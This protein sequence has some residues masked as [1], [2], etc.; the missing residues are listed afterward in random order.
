MTTRRILHIDA[1]ARTG[2]SGIDPRGSHSRR[3]THRFVER[4]RSARPGDV[5]D[6]RDV[7]RAPPAPVTGAWIAAAFAPPERRDAEA[8]ARLA[9][10]DRL[11][12]ELI[13][14]DIVVIGAPMYNFGVPA[15]LK[16]WID[17][18]V[19]VGLTFGFDRKRADVPY[20]PLLPPGKRLVVLSS[21]GDY[22][23]DP[24]GRLDASNLV[25]RG[26]AV[27]MAY[28]GLSD[29]RSVAVEYDEFGD[30]RFAASIA[31]AERAVDALVDR[32]VG[33]GPAATDAV[34][35]AETGRAP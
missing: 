28:I 7:G 3:L 1:S 24:G 19:R 33:E 35:P 30:A 13:G 29:V 14:A 31:A 8:R 27:P 25:E 34:P 16:A 11:V 26:I 23:Y 15:P 22:G 21:R 10:S 9:E 5:V 20:W 6:V 32:L 12:A 4:W 17:S 2:R 18:V